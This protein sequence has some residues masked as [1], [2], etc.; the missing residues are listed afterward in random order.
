M[1]KSPE[2]QAVEKKIS[3]Y[4]KPVRKDFVEQKSALRN[5]GPERT[6]LSGA[7]PFWRPFSPLSLVWRA[8]KSRRF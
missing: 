5:T 7:G 2:E 8:R 4:Q 1:D 6:G 3:Q